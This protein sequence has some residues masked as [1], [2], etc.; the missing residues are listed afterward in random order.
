MDIIKDPDAKGMLPVALDSGVTKLDFWG[1]NDQ[2]VTI[3]NEAADSS[4]VVIDTLEIVAQNFAKVTFVVKK[5]ATKIKNL[6]IK[7]CVVNDWG[8]T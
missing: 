4:E 7:N 3:S 2:E 5:F 1:Y 6:I 8:N